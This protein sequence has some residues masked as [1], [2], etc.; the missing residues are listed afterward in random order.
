M[1]LYVAPLNFKNMLLLVRC[2]D[3]RCGPSL[4]WNSIFF[5]K[6]PLS[7]E[8]LSLLVQVNMPYIKMP[9]WILKK[10]SLERHLRA[11]QTWYCSQTFDSMSYHFHTDTFRKSL[12]AC[13]TDSTDLGEGKTGPLLLVRNK[14]CVHRRSR[15][16][17]CFR[18]FVAWRRL[19]HFPNHSKQH[20]RNGWLTAGHPRY[21]CCNTPVTDCLFLFPTAFLK[22][23]F[24]FSNIYLSST[25]SVQG[26]LLLTWT[27]QH[28]FWELFI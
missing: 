12:W 7:Q 6:S 16:C 3:W 14:N 26:D 24:I 1:L 5:D 13:R 20:H 2:L 21:M 28:L 23:T 4:S 19:G 9:Q 25:K 8:A 22:L 17:D 18:I 15:S 27:L 10:W 11:L